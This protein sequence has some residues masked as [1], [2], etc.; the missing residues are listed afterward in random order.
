METLMKHVKVYLDYFNY[1]AEDF[2]PCEICG[3]GAVDC[4]HIVYRSLGGSDDIENLIGLCRACHNEVH[5]GK[6]VKRKLNDIVRN[7]N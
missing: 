7:R 4:H 6:I 1:G 2:M 3:S 5:A